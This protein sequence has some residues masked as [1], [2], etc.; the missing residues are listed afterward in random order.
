MARAVRH[1]ESW[2][3]GPGR[4]EMEASQGANAALCTRNTCHGQHS[5]VRVGRSNIVHHMVK[6]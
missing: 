1:G 6:I 2:D 3:E 4:G 5:G